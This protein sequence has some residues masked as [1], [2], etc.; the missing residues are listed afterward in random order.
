METTVDKTETK[1]EKPTYLIA[2][3]LFGMYVSFGMSWM[4][5][6]PLFKEILET[7]S[8]GKSEGSWIISVIS[9]AKSIF[10]IVAGILAARIGLNNALRISALL[11]VCG[12]IIPWLPNY[13]FWLVARFLF[14]VGGAMWVTLMG[15]A[16][17]QIFSAKERPI[18]N[19]FNGVAVNIGV[20]LALTFTLSLSE[21]FGWQMT[22]SLYSLIS[23]IFAILLW[24]FGDISSEKATASDD[25]VK[26]TDTLKLPVTWI[27]SIAFTGPLALY[28][29]FNTWLP[30]YYQEAFNIPKL[31]TMGWMTWMNLWGIP[32]AVATGF[33]LQKIKKCKM[34]ILIAA[35]LLPISA[36]GGVMMNDP[37]ILNVV[38][39]L[40]GIGM[41]LPVSPLITLLQTQNGMTP[42]LIGMIL[43][44][45][46][47]VTYILSSIVP[48]IVG[49]CYDR[50]I[51]LTNILAFAC[52]LGLT[53][54]VSLVLP[55]KKEA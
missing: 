15:A 42:K 34:F 11:I 52:L 30:I 26:Y 18:V 16:T 32:A 46:F 12:V 4:G 3:I 36:L 8:I 38:L 40:T 23:A 47:S 20:I 21:K 5:V 28:L 37:A 24:I 35:V 31:Q 39:A 55:E 49:A 51:S 29:V 41:F 44:T 54:A 45:M 43:G 50:H 10:P 33:I 2:F 14:G 48:G 13:M 6:V 9:M 22:L 19:A 25:S 1:K 53:P 17:M 7:L 27:I